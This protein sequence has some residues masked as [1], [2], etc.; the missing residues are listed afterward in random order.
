MTIK[1]AILDIDGTILQTA[2]WQYIHQSLKTWSH[3]KEY[4]NQFFQNK[5]SYEKWAELD[6]ALWKNQP[7]GKID[8]IVKQMP[9]TRGAEQ[10][11]SSLKQEGVKTYLLSAGL[12]QVARRIHEETGSD[13]YIANTLKISE[14]FLTG[15]VEVNVSFNNKD[16]HLCDILKKFDL[17]A[18]EC[19]AVGDDPTLISLFKKVGL[20]IAFNPTDESV[21]K[22][23]HIIVKSND[24]RSILP[25][26]LKRQ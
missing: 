22:H 21:E 25:Y 16:K 24:L 9:Y 23:A 11:I 15:E 5:I 3:A 19:A 20:A 18:D 12:T 17:S 7:S 6:A 8:K 4:R 14:G 1:L 2:S 26:I 10:T 13:G